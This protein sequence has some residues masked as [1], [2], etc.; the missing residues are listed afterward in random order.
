MYTTHIL[1]A[2]ASLWPEVHENHPLQISGQ[3]GHPPI[4]V[5]IEVLAKLTEQLLE[6]EPGFGHESF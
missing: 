6:L 3:V 1:N 2:E 5:S 4:R